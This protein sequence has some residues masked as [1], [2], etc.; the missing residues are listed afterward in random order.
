MTTEEEGVDDVVVD[1]VD[2]AA[3]RCSS[4]AMAALRPSWW[5]RSWFL[6]RGGIR[7]QGVFIFRDESGFEKEK[8]KIMKIGR[9]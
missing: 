8:K 6:R 3:V 2:A 5:Y 9:N 7:R 4:S 1:F